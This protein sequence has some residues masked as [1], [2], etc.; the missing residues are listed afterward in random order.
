MIVPWFEIAHDLDQLELRLCALERT[1]MSGTIERTNAQMMSERIQRI[2]A[3]LFASVVSMSIESANPTI[4]DIGCAA[5]PSASKSRG[6][7]AG[8][9]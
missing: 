2:T 6:S 1:V 8:P 5:Q 9:S 4:P 7:S 3:R